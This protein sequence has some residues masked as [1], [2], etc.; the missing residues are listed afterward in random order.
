M[1]V[2]ER[3]HSSHALS[4]AGEGEGGVEGGSKSIS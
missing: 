2:D 3:G 1:C 4:R